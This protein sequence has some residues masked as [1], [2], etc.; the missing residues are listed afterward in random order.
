MFHRTKR[1]FSTID[2]D[3]LTGI[4]RFKYERFS[5]S[6]QESRAIARK[7]RDVAAIHCGL[8]FADMH[9]KF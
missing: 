6:E 3:F 9:Y 5:N 4:S 8:K 1:Y 2:R 7:P